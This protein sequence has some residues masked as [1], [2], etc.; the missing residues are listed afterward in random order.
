MDQATREAIA[1]ASARMPVL[2]ERAVS[3]RHSRRKGRR[4]WDGDA[5]RAAEAEWRRRRRARALNLPA[6]EYDRGQVWERT[7]G[8]CGIC[9]EAL[10]PDEPWQV[11]HIVPLAMPGS[12]GDVL[13]NTQPSHPICNA[14]KGHRSATSILPP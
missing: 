5:V 13:A 7:C 11:D 8:L 3:R 6:E 2:S 1:A 14:R 12:L 10:D 4:E 9:G